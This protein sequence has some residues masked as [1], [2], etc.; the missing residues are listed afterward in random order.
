M[1]SWTLRDRGP[2]LVLQPL[3]E[4]ASPGPF[5]Q[6]RAAS[7]CGKDHLS[8]VALC[9]EREILKSAMVYI[10]CGSFSC[11]R[12]W[13]K[14]CTDLFCTEFQQGVTCHT[15]PPNQSWV[16]VV[17]PGFRLQRRSWFSHPEGCSRRERSW[18]STLSP[19]RRE[20]FA[21]KIQ[22]CF[23]IFGSCS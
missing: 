16:K 17:L 15:M 8:S 23:P 6:V 2:S 20:V 19:C 9:F 5:L 11:I 21:C 13:I 3:E 12:L 1:A 14:V 7:A 10:G 18:L 4:I 22:N